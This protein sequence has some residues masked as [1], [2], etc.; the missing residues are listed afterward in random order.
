MSSGTKSGT[1]ALLPGGNSRDHGK[2][3]HPAIPSFSR[4]QRPPSGGAE[5]VPSVAVSAGTVKPRGKFD[6]GQENSL[7]PGSIDFLI[8]SG[9]VPVHH[10]AVSWYGAVR[11]G[12]QPVDGVANCHRAA[13]CAE[14][15]CTDRPAIPAAAARADCPTA[16]VRLR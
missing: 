7:A 8:Y 13:N 12:T 3:R 14:S 16:H 6:Q 15:N 4:A 11:T 10:L 2:V 9:P 1:D 5:V